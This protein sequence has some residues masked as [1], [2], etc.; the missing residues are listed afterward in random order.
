MKIMLDGVFNHVGINS[1]LYQKALID[2]QY[3]KFFDFNEKYPEKVR[4][5]ADVLSL[6]ELNL[7]NEDVKNYIYKSEDSVI[8]SYLKQGIDGWRLDVAFDIGYEILNDLTKHAHLVNHQ[9]MIVGEIWNYPKK[10][11]KSIDG[12]MN[13]TLREIILRG[14]KGE[15]TSNQMTNYITKMIEDSGIEGMLKSWNLLDNHDVPRLKD[16]LVERNLQKL[17][18]VMQFTLPGSPNLYYGT[19]LGMDGSG[20]P[21]N[22]AP[23]RWDLYH[24]DNEYLVWTKQLINMHK[25]N[26]AL[27]IGDYV[28]ILSEKLFAYQRV[29]DQVKDT[30][31]T[32]FNLNDEEVTESLFVM[33]SNI[34]NFTD[35]HLLLGDKV[36]AH[37]VAGLLKVTLKKKSFVVLKPYVEVKKSYTSYKRV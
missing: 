5:W 23:M 8:K 4:L 9:S 37:Y 19:E 30:V 35:F 29:T 6:P 36:A 16:L 18:Q 31:I 27:K 24:N 11:F 2:D 21:M 15:L 20:D 32:I 1:K 25:N 14:I 7:E 22:R 13:F 17:A 33:D 34:M 12:I 3:K 26:R 10:W 28:P